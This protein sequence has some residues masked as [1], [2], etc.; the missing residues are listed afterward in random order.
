MRNS[1]MLLA[2]IATA[3]LAGPATAAPLAVQK[4]LP[5]ATSTV[6]NVQWRRGWHGG[7]RGG[8][9]GPGLAAGAIIGGAIAASRPWNYGYYDGYD[10]YA[11]APGYSYAPQVYGYSGGGGGDVG[12][13][14]QRF[15]SY[16]P[17]SGTYLGYDGQR[18]PCP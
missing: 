10:G 17:S 3:V 15:R 6:D 9:W 1:A 11:Y 5:G 7:W 14:M 4:Q 18:H 2:A 16:D 12:Y 13:C 8:G